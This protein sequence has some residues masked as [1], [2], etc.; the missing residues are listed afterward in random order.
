MLAPN[1]KRNYYKPTSNSFGGG[2]LAGTETLTEKQASELMKNSGT[3]FIKNAG[4]VFDYKKQ[5]CPNV[6]YNCQLNGMA[7][8]LTNSGLTYSF[9]KNEKPF[10]EIIP[11]KT[12]FDL[13]EERPGMVTR[14]D[15][16]LVNA[17]ILKQ[18]IVEEELNYSQGA[19]NMYFDKIDES[20]TNLHYVKR[21]VVKEVYPG[22]DWIIKEKDEQGFKYEFIVHPGG[23]YNNIKMRYN[24]ATKVSLNNDKNSVYATTEL[25][26]VSD[27]NLTCFTASGKAVIANYQLN[28]KNELSLQIGNF[29]RNEDLIVDPQVSL[30]RTWATYFGGS[31]EDI[32]WASKIDLIKSQIIVVGRSMS[33]SFPPLG[34][35]NGV[36]IWSNNVGAT[37]AI[38][39]CF[40]LNGTKKWCSY[41][42]SGANEEYRSV[43][44]DGNS[45]IIMVGSSNCNTATAV[46]LYLTPQSAGFYYQGLS[47]VANGQPVDGLITKLGFQGNMLWQAVFGSSGQDA[48]ADVSCNSKNDILICGNNLYYTTYPPNTHVFLNAGGFF[49]S[50]PLNTAYAGGFI[51]RFNSNNQL[52]WSTLYGG[53]G[54]GTTLS[55]ITT[56]INDFIYVTGPVVIGSPQFPVTGPSGS[57]ISNTGGGAVAVFSNSTSLQYAS[58]LG[59]NTYPV[60]I[61][62]NPLDK[63][64]FVCGALYTNVT[65]FPF[66]PNTGYFNNTFISGGANKHS[67]IMQ[68]NSSDAII[69]STLFSGNG[70]DEAT[71]VKVGSGGTIFLAGQ[72]KRHSTGVADNFPRLNPGSPFYYDAVADATTSDSYIAMFQDIR[73]LKWCTYYG[74]PSCNE[75]STDLDVNGRILMY[76]GWTDNNP[77]LST[78]TTQ[79]EVGTSWI[80]TGLGLYQYDGIIAKFYN[81]LNQNLKTSN[82]IETGNEIR[83]LNNPVSNGELSVLMA[84]GEYKIEDIYLIDFTGHKIQLVNCEKSGQLIKLNY[85]NISKGMYILRIETNTVSKSIKVVFN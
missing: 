78:I 2:G 4:Q 79:L 82:A 56:D 74:T 81:Q 72:N 80:Q 55:S 22:I 8:F 16:E 3:G 60:S 45:N 84:N 24:G 83:L 40:E 6:F 17:S 15:I 10:T 42:G 48:I 38:V 64:F 43:A 67:F 71:S 21:L 58:M 52:T 13:Q 27:E 75:Y 57:Y 5:P 14:L 62:V 20:K 70:D 41:V 59:G 54:A 69:W 35:S 66:V 73:N 33:V 85:G 46:P 65:G 12:N 76:T 36:A 30:S 29:D 7:I 11:S 26:N 39:C 68:F 53:G 77:S 1:C 23:D 61:A 63:S 25:G 28:S 51:A 37:D 34:S 32:L 44:I 31:G 49:Y 19:V 18:N 47:Q 50:P 9:V